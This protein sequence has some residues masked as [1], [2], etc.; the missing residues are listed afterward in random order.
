MCLKKTSIHPL[1]SKLDNMS[2]SRLASVFV[3]RFYLAAR[4][5][6]HFPQDGGAGRGWSPCNHWWESLV[7][8]P[9]L[10]LLQFQWLRPS[11]FCVL[12]TFSP[13][14]CKVVASSCQVFSWGSFP[15][16]CLKSIQLIIE[17]VVRHGGCN[18][19]RHQSS[20]CFFFSPSVHDDIMV[21]V[22]SAA[23]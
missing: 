17:A 11:L 19:K 7:G 8:I 2:L 5:R 22:S 18:L 20:S 12:T 6:C 21:K 4:V 3:V 14:G 16:G 1:S 10:L 13:S 15:D 9:A 23:L